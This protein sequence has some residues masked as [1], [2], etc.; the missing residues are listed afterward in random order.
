MAQKGP[1]GNTPSGGGGGN[2][3]RPERNKEFDDLL[4]K[5]QDSFRG[6]FGD[7]GRRR[8]GGG[9]PN[10]GKIIGLVVVALVVLWLGSGLYRVNP[11]ELGV[12]LRFGEYH[13]TTGPG[14]NYH[15]PYPVETVMIPSV[16]SVNKVEVGSR[17]GGGRTSATSKE[18]LMLTGDR[19]IVDIDFEVQWKID[20]TVPQNF[21]FNVRDPEGTIKPVAESAM[22]EVIGQNKLGDVLTTA[23]SEIAEDTRELMQ[24]MLDEYGAGVEIIAVNLSRPDVPQP[25]ID[26]FQD[27]KRAEQDRETAESVAEGYR[28]Q[29]IPRAKGEAVKMVQDAEAYKAR[30]TAE[31]E[32]DAARFV[33]VYTE[34]KQAED[35]TRKRIY[36]ETMEELMS[37]MNKIVIDQSGG[38]TQGVLPYLPLNE[39]RSTKGASNE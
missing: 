30:V 18:S 9:D 36:L 5:S 31:A 26:E 6:M 22:R 2:G 1:W 10:S 17:T 11:D 34:Y 38:G 15:L 19:N 37:G 28:N 23:Q 8:T 27:V 33:S 21:L 4:R 7:G 24:D 35:V 20:S 14:L 16:T 39:L 3:R 13:R 29:I 25:V 12:V 32:G